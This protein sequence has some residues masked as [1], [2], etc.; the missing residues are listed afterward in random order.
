MLLCLCTSER[1]RLLGECIPDCVRRHS[2]D[3]NLKNNLFSSVPGFNGTNCENNIDDCPGHQCANGGTCIDGVNTYNC[4][5][6]PEWTGIERLTVWSSVLDSSV[7]TPCISIPSACFHAK[8]SWH[9]TENI[10]FLA[11]SKSYA[12][13]C[14]H[15]CVFFRRL[16]ATS[17]EVE[18]IFV[19]WSEIKTD[20]HLY[21]IS[22]VACDS[23]LPAMLLMSWGLIL[24]IRCVWANKVAW[25]TQAF[26][27]PR[28]LKYITFSEPV[29]SSYSYLCRDVQMWFYIPIKSGAGQINVWVFLGGVH[30]IYGF[31][32]Q[33]R[34]WFNFLLLSTGQHCTEDVNECRL[35]PNTCQ[36]GGT[37]SNLIGGYVC[38]CVNGWSGFDCSENI[39]DCA[40]A[41]CS[42][43]STCVDRVASFVCLCPHGKKGRPWRRS[44]VNI[45]YTHT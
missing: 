28:W 39:D 36:N 24:N 20:I 1:I 7:F 4:Q 2:C 12:C 15:A 29:M 8:H 26:H 9:T 13:E 43:G 25:Y 22:H 6:R 38:V 18:Q 10:W 45:L 17:S 44:C 19:L 34:T 35:Q 21:Y 5:C 42:P 40:T 30:L 37:C 32:F 16:Y 41:A 14:V 23:V 3:Y 33:V 11:W 27:L 31:M